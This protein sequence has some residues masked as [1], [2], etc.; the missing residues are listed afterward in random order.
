MRR[1]AFTLIE[2]MISIVILSIIMTF[3]YQSY[4]AINLSNR[5][6]AKKVNTIKGEQLKQRILYMDLSLAL[7]DT[8]KIIKQEKNEDVIL[9]Q[10]S[11]SIHRRYNP[12]IAYILNDKKLYRLE[13]LKE[14]K[15]PLSIDSNYVIDCFGEVN[16]FRVY[17]STKAS[18]K[19]KVKNYLINVN[20]KNKNDIL[21][22]VKPLNQF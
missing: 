14:I 8:I 4:A 16:T 22:R 10:S 13:S 18:D 2:M 20:F 19:K 3:L 5:I 7:Y 12:F 21:I 9:M 6:Y 1:E 17:P 15:Y 11:N